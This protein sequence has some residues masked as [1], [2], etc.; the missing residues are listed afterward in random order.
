[1]LRALTAIGVLHESRERLYS[2]TSLGV[3]TEQRA[4]LYARLGALGLQR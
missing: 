1:L 3:T 2:L 4:W